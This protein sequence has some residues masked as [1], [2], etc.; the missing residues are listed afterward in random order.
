MLGSF[1][2]MAAASVIVLDL[3]ALCIPVAPP[4]AQSP[5]I[6][7]PDAV[8]SGPV[9]LQC[10]QPIGWRHTKV[11]QRCGAVEHAQLSSSGGLDVVGQPARERA[12]PDQL[13]FRIRK[14]LD[15]EL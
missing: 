2:A 1:F 14:A 10:L 3:N 5:L 13:S 9:A 4:E 7:D 8:L 6:V 11:I 12:C 15:H